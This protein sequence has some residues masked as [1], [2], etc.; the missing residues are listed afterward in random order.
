MHITLLLFP[1]GLEKDQQLVSNVFFVDCKAAQTY[2][3]HLIIYVCV[4]TTETDDRGHTYNPLKTQNFSP[5]NEILD[6]S[7]KI[8]L[9]YKILIF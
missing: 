1:V 2:D 6:I 4:G 9:E 7:L 8:P 3:T 5:F